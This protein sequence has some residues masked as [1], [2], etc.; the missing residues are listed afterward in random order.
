MEE[1]RRREVREGICMRLTGGLRRREGV[2]RRE[3]ECHGLRAI[4]VEA[5]VEMVVDEGVDEGVEDVDKVNI[6]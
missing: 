3:R 2:P 5:V 4:V 1:K 6:G